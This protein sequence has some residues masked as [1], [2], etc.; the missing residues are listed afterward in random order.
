[1]K[2]KVNVLVMDVEELKNDVKVL[3]Q[4]SIQPK[5][6]AQKSFCLGS[7][8]VVKVFKGLFMVTVQPAHYSRLREHQV[9]SK[10]S[11]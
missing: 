3:K 10:G 8:G 4:K 9:M 5:D 11:H 6:P 7:F 1:M 2:M